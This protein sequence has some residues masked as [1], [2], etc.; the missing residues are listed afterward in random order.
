[1][2]IC[3]KTQDPALSAPNQRLLVKIFSGSSLKLKKKLKKRVSTVTGGDP[4]DFIYSRI[5]NI[6]KFFF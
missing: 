5:P 4:L 6:L 1:M 3:Q 2:V